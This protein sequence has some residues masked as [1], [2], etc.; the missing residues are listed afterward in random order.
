[1]SSFMRFFRGASGNE[2]QPQQP[3]QPARSAQSSQP[4]PSS[5]GSGGGGGPTS[6]PKAGGQQPQQHNKRAYGYGRGHGQK[7]GV[8]ATAAAR[9]AEGLSPSRGGKAAK[10]GDG[11]M[12]PMS[13]MAL[14]QL[15]GYSD[16]LDVSLHQSTDR[17]VG[18]VHVSM[19]ANELMT[20]QWIHPFNNPLK[21]RIPLQD[22]EAEVR[23][24]EAAVRDRRTPRTRLLE[25]KDA[26]AQLNG[27]LEK[28][29]LSGGMTD[30]GSPGHLAVRRYLSIHTH[31]NASLCTKSTAAVH[32]RGL[33]ADGG[34]RGGE[35]AGQG[36]AQV[37]Q[38]E[39]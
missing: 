22:L 18:L 19:M 38:Q 24:I 30:R 11:T 31:T 36:D 33:G 3:Q 10:T 2:E 37:A 32:G 15:Q 16:Q 25:A 9:A 35:G 6:S 14:K 7:A 8:A 39:M 23:A 1:M 28:V 12:S 4:R 17:R 21:Y 20:P 29:R 5:G 13:A 26:V 34:A 27:S